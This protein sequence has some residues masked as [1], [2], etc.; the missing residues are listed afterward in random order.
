MRKLVMNTFLSIFS[1][2][3]HQDLFALQQVDLSLLYLCIGLLI[4]VE[5]AFIPAAPLPCDSVIVLCGSLAAVGVLN[6]YAIIGVLVF[7]GWLGSAIAFYQGHQLKEWRLVSTWLNKVSEKQWRTTDNL[8]QRYGLLAMFMG[9]FLPVVRSL[10]PMVIGLRNAVT[11]T[12]FL[13]VSP[14][15]ALAWILFLVGS[16]FGISLLP[17]KLAKI[18]NHALILA[19]LM[20]LLIAIS[21]L[22]VG[23]LMRKRSLQK[24]PLISEE[25]P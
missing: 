7:A 6:L 13:L 25:R 12:R 1:A 14:L 3:W 4:F 17:D 18:A 5:S 9:R 19:P 16:G 21:T 22:M 11:P 8:I 10:L 24:A 15:S 23:W 2:L 20:T